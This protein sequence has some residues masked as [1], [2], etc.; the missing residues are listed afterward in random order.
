MRFLHWLILKVIIH[1]VT[2]IKQWKYYML[3]SNQINSEFTDSSFNFSKYIFSGISND[4][5]KQ[6]YREDESSNT[7]QIARTITW[8]C[9]W[10]EHVSMSVAKKIQFWGHRHRIFSDCQYSHFSFCKL[11]CTQEWQWWNCL[12]SGVEAVNWNA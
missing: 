2:L 8:L 9:G 4:K 1:F 11:R 5:F 3:S 6:H 10:L 12:L 7:C